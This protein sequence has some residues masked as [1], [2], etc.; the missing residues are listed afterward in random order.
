VGKNSA[1]FGRILV[2]KEKKSA[3][4]HRVL[5]KKRRKNFMFNSLLRRKLSTAML[6]TRWEL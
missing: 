6:K 1:A 2:K 5:S 3:C 4:I